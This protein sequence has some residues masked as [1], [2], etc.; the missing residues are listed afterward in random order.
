[1]RVN[2]VR[3]PAAQVSYNDPLTGQ[4]EKVQAGRMEC[5]M[6]NIADFMT[7]RLERPLGT[8]EAASTELSTFL[9]YNMR[10]KVQ[11]H[12]ASVGVGI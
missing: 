9:V 2:R 5:T 7:D 11:R 3:P 6:Q 10:R 4:E 8:G 12:H 1:M